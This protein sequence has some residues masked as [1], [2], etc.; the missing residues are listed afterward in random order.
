MI[1]VCVPSMLCI[2]Q[3]YIGLHWNDTKNIMLRVFLFHWVPK[4]LTQ[5]MP[6]PQLLCTFHTNVYHLV[7]PPLPPCGQYSWTWFLH[8][9]NCGNLTVTTGYITTCIIKEAVTEW[10]ISRICESTNNRNIAVIVLSVQNRRKVSRSMVVLL[11]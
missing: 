4:A 10:D 9:K 1:V 11:T 8:I 7:T 3:Q 5:R 6:H 2:S